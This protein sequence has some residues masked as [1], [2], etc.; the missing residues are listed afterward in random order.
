MSSIND[1][2]HNTGWT[3]SNGQWLYNGQPSYTV[4]VLQTVTEPSAVA[5][6]LADSERAHKLRIAQNKGA[7]QS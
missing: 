7:A 5:Q 6:I 1:T 3:R 4:A 2:P